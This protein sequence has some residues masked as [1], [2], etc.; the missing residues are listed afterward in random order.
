MKKIHFIIIG[1]LA[2]GIVLVWILMPEKKEKITETKNAEVVE[3]E[4]EDVEKPKE[5]I[6][7][8]AVGDVMLSRHVWTKIKQSGD[9]ALPFRETHEITSMADV[10]FANLETSVSTMQEPPSEGMSFMA[11]PRSLEG[12]KLGGFDVISLAN[13]HS[14]NFGDQALLDTIEIV[15]E[16]GFKT[17]GAGKDYDD[18]NKPLI[19]EVKNQKI[20]FFA[21]EDVVPDSYASGVGDPG[22]AWMDT[23]VMKKNVSALKKANLVDYIIVSMH[24]GVE[25]V[26]TPNDIQV[27]FAR[28]AIDAG[29]N[30]VM[31]HHPHVTQTKE[32]YKN[33]YI[34]YSLGNFVF[35]QMWS[36][37]T[38][39]GEIFK[40][41]LDN[42]EIKDIEFMKTKIYDY[43]Q[44]RVE[45]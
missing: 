12:L 37:E 19:Y 44:P 3:E 13:N 36:E 39:M 35:D 41:T 11:D 26:K 17:I 43:N 40:C 28:S 2:L 7:L 16:N 32:T 20:A 21:Y 9:M 42:G 1:L 6:S 8:I 10:S 33:G 22:V 30:L 29:A 18:A 4:V 27:K 31:G 23:E 25:Y 14:H 24:S 34:I 45:N 38:R 5:P 15:N